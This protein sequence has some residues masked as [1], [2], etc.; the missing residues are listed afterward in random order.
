MKV[1]DLVPGDLIQFSVNSGPVPEIANGGPGWGDSMKVESNFNWV[2][3][4]GMV[5]RHMVYVGKRRKNGVLSYEVL[6]NNRPR[7]IKGKYI[8]HLES[9]FGSECIQADERASIAPKKSK[10]VKAAAAR[11]GKAGIL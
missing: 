1:H 4:E 9:V 5:P 11:T 8:R 6:W 3:Q 10:H 2:W 7:M